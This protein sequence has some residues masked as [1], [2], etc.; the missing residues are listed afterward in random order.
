M[1][2]NFITPRKNALA[3]LVKI[4]SGCLI[5]WYGLRA[6]GI[7][8]PYWAMISL[9]IVTE[10][11]MTVAKANFRAR[12][13]NTLSG[14]VVSCIALVIFG[15]TFLAMLVALTA[16][17]IVAMLLQNYPSNWRLGPATVVILLSAAFSGN[18]LNQELHLA[19]MRVGE[20]IVGS[21]VAL[22]QTVIYIWLV[23]HRQG[24]DGP[25]PPA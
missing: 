8:E 9:I 20:V 24:H 14:C 3:Y 10:P 2:F 4:L 7:E 11:D 19:F 18:G 25:P 12:L 13:I 5:L 6:A 22:L 21:T 1:E 16:A 17:V 23:K 15:P